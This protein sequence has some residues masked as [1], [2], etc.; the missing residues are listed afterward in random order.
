[1]MK[2]GCGLALKSGWNVAR[3]AR[4]IHRERRERCCRGMSCRATFLVYRG[5]YTLGEIICKS[6]KHVGVMCRQTRCVSAWRAA[7]VAGATG[8]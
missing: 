7:E 8:R 5:Q 4:G 6:G 3:E 2:P 1:M